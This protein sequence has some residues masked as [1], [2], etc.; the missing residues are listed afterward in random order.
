MVIT[1]Y[2]FSFR[3]LEVKWLVLSS[4]ETWKDSRSAATVRHVLLALIVTMHVILH[5]SQT[6][7]PHEFKK[8][9]SQ[10]HCP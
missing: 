3:R 8:N 10:A 2:R 4:H 9:T 5:S 1:V 7:R 6:I